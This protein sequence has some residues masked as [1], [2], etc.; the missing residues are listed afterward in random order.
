MPRRSI[1]GIFARPWHESARVNRKILVDLLLERRG[2]FVEIGP[3]ASPLLSV[4]PAASANRRVAIDLAG[5]L[6]ACEALGLEC[7]ARDAGC[8]RWPLDDETA[9]VVVSNQTL[10]HIAGTDHFM[11]ESHRTLKPGGSLIISVPNQGALAYVLML[12]L[13]MNPPMNMVSDQY[14]GLGTPFSSSRFQRNTRDGGRAHLR[15][16][17]TRAMNDLLL[18]HGFQVVRNF[19]AS[20][21]TPILGPELAR[22]LPHYGLFT[23][24]LARKPTR[25]GMHPFGSRQS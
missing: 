12:L 9:D 21:G 14:L 1:P 22:V 2:T 19:G 24:V 6:G 8:D 4:I 10:E 16:F 17:A 3:G 18:V 13:T 25:P 15:L 5:S 7:H 11:A 20:W 23:T